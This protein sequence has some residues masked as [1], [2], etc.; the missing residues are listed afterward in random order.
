MSKVLVTE[1]YLQ[2]IADAIREKVGDSATYTPAQMGD[3]IRNIPSGA[4]GGAQISTGTFVSASSQYGIVDIDCG[5]KPDLVMV[6]LPFGSNDTTSYWWKDASWAETSAI[7]ALR[8]AENNVYV[9]ALGRTTGETGIQQIND[10]GFSFMSNGGNTRGV[11]CKYIA[12][13]YT[14]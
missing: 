12:V 7:W 14:E 4:G 1:D 11:A 9:V 3:A 8:P 10:D 2:D 5:F 6:T 13:K